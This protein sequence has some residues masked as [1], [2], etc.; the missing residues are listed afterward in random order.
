MKV[1]ARV[2]VVTGAGSG[3]GRALSLLLL[4]KGASVA[5][6]DLNESTLQETASLAG[7]RKDRI[8]THVVNI[9]DRNAVEHL[10]D[11]VIAAHGAVDGIINCAGII[12]RFIRFKDLPYADIERMINV[13]F[14]G[15]VYMTKAFL[16]HLLSRPEGHVVNIASMGAF[17]PVPGQTLYGASKAATKL[18]TEGLYS[19][20]T[21]TNVHVTVV[22]PGAIETNIVANS[23]V[24]IKASE[25]T[26]N[27]GMKTTSARVAAEVIVKSIERNSF[28]VLVGNDA[29]MMD[30]LYRLMPKRATKFI[31]D[32]MGA[33]LDR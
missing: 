24:T 19:E 5:A 23:G 9:T 28:R 11:Q 8:S 4:E 21:G 18:F 7:S 6:V 17:L 31:Y 25:S 10:P 3:M 13:N 30:F 2:W 1:E 33:L 29:K 22:F 32:Q 26:S 14:Y 12:Q 20:L 16:P 15:T 27:K